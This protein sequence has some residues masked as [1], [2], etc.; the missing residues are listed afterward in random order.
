M[1]RASFFRDSCG[2]QAVYRHYSSGMFATKQY[3]MM[4]WQT[5]PPI[6][7]KWKISWEPKFLCLELK[8][9]SFKA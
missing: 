1:N 7:N 5:L 6:T 3:I 9:G 8:I 4:K 2:K